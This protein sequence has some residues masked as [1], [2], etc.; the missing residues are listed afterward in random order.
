MSTADRKERE[1]ERRRNEIIDAAEKLFFSR[2]YESV[3]M[4]DIAKETELARGT[5]YLY[6]KNKDNIYIAIGI[7]GLKILNGLFK[8][9]YL[10]GES[11]IE[12]IQSMLLAVYEFSKKYPGY[13]ATIGNLQGRGLDKKDFPEMEEMES[14]HGDSFRIV[15]EAFNVGMRDGTVRSDVDPAKAAFILTASI[16]SVLNTSPDDG[17]VEYAVDMML[18]SVEGAK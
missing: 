16:Q 5:L 7:R 2:G 18:R 13:Y 3:T 6:F 11:G 8:E 4:D 17:L 14:V 15:L 10:K 1:K 9:G 12:K